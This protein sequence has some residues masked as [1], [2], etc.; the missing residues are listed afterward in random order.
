MTEFDRNKHLS[1]VHGI[2]VMN[3]LPKPIQPQIDFQP[4]INIQ[5]PPEFFNYNNNNANDNIDNEEQM[6]KLIDMQKNFKET[7]IQLQ[8]KKK[9]EERQSNL[10]N[11]YGD[12][13]DGF[14]KVFK[15]TLNDFKSMV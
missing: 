12:I 4:Q 9:E 15:D 5:F 2:D 6:K 3:P 1:E 7:M 8:E 14:Q 13:S 11:N 10:R